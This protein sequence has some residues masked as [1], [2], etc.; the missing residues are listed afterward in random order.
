MWENH[1][2]DIQDKTR[3]THMKKMS[4]ALWKKSV[5]TVEHAPF[6][7]S[8]VNVMV[9]FHR[10]PKKICLN[11]YHY[12]KLHVNS[13]VRAQN[14]TSAI[15]QFWYRIM[16]PGSRIYNHLGCDNSLHNPR[17]KLGFHFNFITKLNNFKLYI[18]YKRGV[19]R[20]G[21]QVLILVSV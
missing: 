3:T 2:Y 10:N 8:I 21:W 6:S 5:P 12:L 20:W 15:N 16:L 1:L 13:V 4:E 14:K 19:R 9:G 18:L 11:Y 17:E 7:F